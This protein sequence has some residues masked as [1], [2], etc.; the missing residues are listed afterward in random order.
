[1]K[2]YLV[3]GAVRDRLLDLPVVERDWVVVGAT[4]DE[5]L[6]EGFRRVEGDFPVFL[7]PQTGDEYALARTEVK[8]GPGYQGFQVECGPDIRLQQDL[9]RRDLTINALA[10]D[11][12]GNL[13]DVCHGEDDLREGLLRHIT[14][15][16]IE[17]P[18]RLLRI[19][20]F[21]AKLGRWG[22]RVAHGTHRLMKAMA[23]SEDLMSL[24]SERIWREMGRALAEPQPW[25]F[26]E[27]LHG[28]G[29]LQRLL[30]DVAA[31]MGVAAGHGKGESVA[32]MSAL[33]RAVA[34]T[35][36]SAV[37]GAAALFEAA[38][39]Q[40]DPGLWMANLRLDKAV[41]LLLNDL[42]YFNRQ[43][44][45][46]GR[47]A[48]LLKLA[49]RLKPQQQP[50]RF[51]RFLQASRGLWPELMTRLAP[52]LELAGE[53]VAAGAPA[54]LTGSPLEGQALGQAIQAWRVARLEEALRAMEASN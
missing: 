1:M 37:R 25:R 20:R 50:E 14:P 53:I 8:S 48:P 15:A 11:E 41:R 38:R 26:F 29:A 13:I 51:R 44:L 3:G 46:R 7:H 23:A 27:L 43:T 17:D 34:V 21:A 40:R 28:C 19:A 12:A 33:K 9:L 16:F 52:R 4:P 35:E 32:V 6:T 49:M 30:P 5:M 10:M 31:G 18:V 45:D 36:D 24:T 22:F 39:Q 2:V 54:E 47:A 42:L